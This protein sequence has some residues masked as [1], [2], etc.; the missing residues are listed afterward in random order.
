MFQ[1]GNEIGIG[2]AKLKEIIAHLEATYCGSVGVEYVYIRHPEVMAWLREKME[3]S[4]NAMPFTPEA[5]RHIYRHLV[6]AVGFENYIHK[7]F[8]GAKRFSLEGAKP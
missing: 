4:R 1:A 2:P 7:K 3:S 6:Q 8:V 5:R